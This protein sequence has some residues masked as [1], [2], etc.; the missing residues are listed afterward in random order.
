MES[1][2][3]FAEYTKIIRPEI[4]EIIG[5]YR[6]VAGELDK[7]WKAISEAEPILN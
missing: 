7:L 4:A 3:S 5:Q 6:A 2:T 1:L